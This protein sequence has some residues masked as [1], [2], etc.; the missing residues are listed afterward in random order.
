MSSKSIFTVTL[1]FAAAA[2]TTTAFAHPGHAGHDGFTAG[3]LHPFTGAD[4]LLAMLG[5]GL[6][7]SQLG[8]RAALALPAAFIAFMLAGGLAA[9]AS[10]PMTPSLVESIIAASV[11]VLGLLI[12]TSFKAPVSIA[13]ALAGGFA[14]FHGY[15]HVAEMSGGHIATYALGFLASTT[16]LLF[17]GLALGHL[18]RQTGSPRLVRWIGAAVA[19]AGLLIACRLV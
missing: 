16:F 3:L 15:A 14:V 19:V 8:R 10:A 17:S 2:F 7:A 12:A 18:L 5:V 4:H 9:S 13:A 1:T 11:L 6:W